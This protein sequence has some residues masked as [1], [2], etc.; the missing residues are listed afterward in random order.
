MEFNKT[1]LSNFRKDFKEM[2]IV[3]EKKY[4]IFIETGSISYDENSFAMKINAIKKPENGISLEQTKFE[5][6]CNSFGF[7]KEDYKKE[8]R[9][10]G[11]S[12]IYQFI[13]FKPRARKNTCIIRNPETETNYVVPDEIVKLYLTR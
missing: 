6:N 8:V 13:G 11:E 7:K 4:N 2:V 12:T 5:E 9:I 1:E 3:L 10:P